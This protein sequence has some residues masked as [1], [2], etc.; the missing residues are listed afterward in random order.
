MLCFANQYQRLHNCRTEFEKQTNESARRVSVCLATLWD[1]MITALRVGGGPKQKIRN[2][3]SGTHFKFL[4]WPVDE[5]YASVK[6]ATI[7]SRML[8]RIMCATSGMHKTSH[9]LRL[10]QVE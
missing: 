3:R 9:M 10:L 2:Q 1:S 5:N 4:F 8:A 7:A 6:T